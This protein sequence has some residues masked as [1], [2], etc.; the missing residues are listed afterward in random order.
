[1]PIASSLV[2]SKEVVGVN[3]TNN[4][5]DDLGKIEEIVLQ[6]VEGNVVYVVLN[7]GSFLGLGGKLFALPWKSIHYDNDKE[8]F[9]LDVDIEDLKNAPGFDKDHWP[10]MADETWAQTI[11]EFYSRK[12]PIE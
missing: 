10:N 1:M 12:S 4:N 2:K 11:T 6:K 9:I 5:N 7:S 3:V 8:S